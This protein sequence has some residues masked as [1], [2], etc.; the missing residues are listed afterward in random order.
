VGQVCLAVLTIAAGFA[1]QLYGSGDYDHASV[2][3]M[4]ELY[5][6]GD[7]LSQP[8][9]ALRLARCWQETGRPGRA[10][11][12]YLFL[13]ERLPGGDLRG[14]AWMGAA[15]VYEETG[16]FGSA[17]DGYSIA[18]ASF[19]DPLEQET[20]KVLAALCLGRAGDW[21]ASSRELDSLASGVCGSRLAAGVEPLAARASH[22]PRRSPLACGAAS[23]LVPGLGQAACGCWADAL[24]ALGTTAVTAAAFAWSL[25]E[26]D[27]SASILMG[28][29]A[30]SFYGG[31]VYGGWRAASR[32]NSAR[33]DEIYDEIS[34]V[35]SEHRER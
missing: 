5:E 19:D 6:A 10:L 16:M 20:C 30:V 3:Y 9:V 18:A 13:S 14:M 24:T 26:G 34:G 21:E 17:R 12:M 15:S 22:P 11:G 8:L 2:E 23:A 27:T 25:E 29:L 35:L 28:W 7:T 4:R 31:N 1:D 32:Y 33:M